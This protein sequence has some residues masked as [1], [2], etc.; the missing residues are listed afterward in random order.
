NQG[1]FRIVNRRVERV[2]LPETDAND[3]V[4]IIASDTSGTVWFS[5]GLHV[6]RWRAGRLSSVARP[7]T[8]PRGRISQ[9]YGDSTGRLWIGFTGGTA[10]TIDSGWEERDFKEATGLHAVHQGIYDIFEDGGGVI[11]VLGSGGLSRW[12]GEHFV[13]LTQAAGLPPSRI[14]AMTED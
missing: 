6:F 3:P 4:M 2:A 12:S 1:L 8:A 9:I 5:D 11:W 13:T 14:G 10:G 7:A